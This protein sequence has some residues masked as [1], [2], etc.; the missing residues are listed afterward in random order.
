MRRW[1]VPLLLCTQLCAPL[2]GPRL[3]TASSAGPAEPDSRVGVVMAMM[4]G[5]SIRITPLAPVPWAGIA[6]VSCVA[7]LVNAF[8]EPD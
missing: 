5:V 6:A 1:F 8:I 4:C 2:A 7:A 3:A